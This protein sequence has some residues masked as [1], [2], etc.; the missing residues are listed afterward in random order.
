MPIEIPKNLRIPTA[1]DDKSGVLEKYGIAAPEPSTSVGDVAKELAAG[2]TTAVGS[3]IK[4]VG[5]AADELIA[6]GIKKATGSRPDLRVFGKDP[7]EGVTKSLRESKTLEGEMAMR[8]STPTGDIFDP[9]SVSL[10]EDPSLGGYAQ[11]AAAVFGQFAPQAAVA[12]GT[13]KLSGRAQLGTG[14][15]IG[16]AQGAGGAATEEGARIRGMQHADLLAGSPEYADLIGQ[17]MIPENAR[18]ILAQKAEAGSGLGG[19]IPAA[20]GGVAEQA[21]LRGKIRLPK[22]GGGPVTTAAAAAVGGGLVEGAQEVTE[23]VGQRLGASMA[24]GEKRNLTEDSF[25]N[26]VLGAIGGGALAGGVSIID[27][28]SRRV[29]DD[30]TQPA[31][32][33][34]PSPAGPVTRALAVAPGT[35]G[36][37]SNALFGF[38]EE[39][40]QKRADILT[41]QGRPSKVVPH[42]VRD[43]R[44]AVIPDQYGTAMD[45]KGRI[46]ALLTEANTLIDSIPEGSITLPRGLTT[47]LQEID[48][49]MEELRDKI[50]PQKAG[51]LS[52]GKVLGDKEETQDQDIPLDQRVKAALELPPFQRTARDLLILRQNRMLA[53]KLSAE[54]AT[55]AKPIVIPDSARR[56]EEGARQAA[57]SP[58]NALPEPTDAQKDAGNYKL[59]RARVAGLDIS[60]ENPAGSVRRS[61]AGAPKKWENTM[62]AHYGYFKGVPARAPD[63][64]HVDVFVKPG[65]PEE[66]DGM[67]FVIDQNQENGKFDEPKVMLGYASKDEAV[68]AY[69]SHY[70]AGWDS[71]I[72]GVLE[73]SMEQLQ[74]RLTDK[75][76]FLKPQSD[77]DV[78]LQDPETRQDL[79]RMAGEAGWAEMGGKLLRDAETND[80]AGRAKWIPKAPWWPGRPDGMNENGVREAVRKA[81][82]GEKLRAAERRMI[83]Y[84]VEQSG[85]E[86]A[87]FDAQDSASEEFL[88][89]E[90]QA[91][92]F[93]EATEQDQNDALDLAD[94]I[95]SSVSVDAWDDMTEVDR[96]KE[97]DD[98]FGKAETAGQ[99]QE[100]QPESAEDGAR[101]GPPKTGPPEAGPVTSEPAAKTPSKEGVSTSTTETVAPALELSGES[102]AD[103][104][105]KSQSEKNEA[106]AQAEAETRDAA[107]Q[108]RDSFTLTGSARAADEGAARGQDDLLTNGNE[109]ARYAIKQ[110]G[111]NIH[112]A[113]VQRPWAQIGQS[114]KDTPA[115]R[116]K[117][118]KVIAD[119]NGGARPEPKIPGIVEGYDRGDL[120]TQVADPKPI[121]VALTASQ[122]P[123]DAVITLP[124]KVEETGE[125]HDVEFNARDAFKESSRKVKRLE[126]L[127]ACVRG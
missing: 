60:V 65:T 92:G 120:L 61:K 88:D 83:D 34:P 76:G 10:G 80:V 79:E 62:S 117:M 38:T 74:D 42:P 9:K 98:I 36:E 84:M 44:F 87:E 89:Q 108:Q 73:L 90:L 55:K 21:L 116:T 126:A 33:P 102:P 68:Q 70:D 25:A 69:L 105:A 54:T 41:K 20:I 59:G 5:L 56:N 101:T 81:L 13:R 22:L 27:G 119:F 77:G 46:D 28:E 26:A 104:A 127:A 35:S 91:V 75:R 17:G 57:T 51:K 97:L 125:I 95:V 64:D 29:P 6:A 2:A 48:G 1:A 37:S 115:N 52:E 23:G 109:S 67:A 16:G 39:G 50:A 45:D 58:D 86:R 124:V 110:D 78:A 71:R 111:G 122:I 7:L 82:A 93:D 15:A 49:E 24:T 123:T 96:E 53:E 47:R 11:Q 112:I 66:S 3:T 72:R 113:D 63:K 118:G 94:D 18:E 14:A 43:G 114:F 99:S 4:G 106:K 40:A 121:S 31:G 12:L 100:S 103:L 32:T 107:D 30:G 8:R 19:G 85:M